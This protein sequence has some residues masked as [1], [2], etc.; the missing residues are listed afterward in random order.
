MLKNMLKQDK[1]KYTVPRS[2]H[3]YIPITA[4]AD[5]CTAYEYDTNGNVV[6]VNRTKESKITSTYS[7]ADL[8]HYASG[9]G[10]EFDY[11]Y[12]SPHNV[13]KVTWDN[14]TNTLTYNA[15]GLVT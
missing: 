1:E 11:T 9:T 15:A 2:V 14:L 13:T 5:N 4:I 3:D 12:D 10:A 7:G 8:T 6:A